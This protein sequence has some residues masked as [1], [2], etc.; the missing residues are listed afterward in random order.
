MPH[1][2]IPHL[3]KRKYDKHGYAIQ[4]VNLGAPRSHYDNYILERGYY[5]IWHQRLVIDRALTKKRAEQIIERH[6][7]ERRP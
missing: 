1:H 6:R 7:G 5:K 2:Q 3:G 4:R